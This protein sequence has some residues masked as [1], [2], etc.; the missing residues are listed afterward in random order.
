MGISAQETAD[1]ANANAQYASETAKGY[2]EAGKGQAGAAA[3]K[4]KQQGSGYYDAAADKAGKAADY[5]KDSASS[6]WAISPPDY[7]LNSSA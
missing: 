1:S 3:A 7:H 2:A 4:A 5:V 6:G